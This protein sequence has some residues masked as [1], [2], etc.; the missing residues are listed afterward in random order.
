MADADDK[1][2]LIVDGEKLSGLISKMLA[3]D[4]STDVAHNGLNAVQKLREILPHAIVVEVDIPGNGIKLTELLG[5]NPKYSGVPIIL[6]A[7]NP[8]PD[9]II[10]SKNAGADSFLAKPFKPSDLKGRIAQLSAERSEAAASATAS[11]STEVGE[12]GQPVPD[13]SK[14]GDQEDENGLPVDLTNRVKS[15]EGLPSFPATHAEILKLA[16]SEDATSDD[17]AEKLQLD[18]GLLAT[19]F[20]LVNSS[21]YGFRKKVDSLKLAVTLLGLEEIANLVMAAQVF[22]KLGD[23]ED[24]SGLDANEFWRHSIGVAFA[25]RAISKKL[26]TEAESAFLAG[27]LHDVGKIVLDRYFVDYYKEVL[28]ICEDGKTLI[29]DAEKDVLGVTHA[30][31]GAVLASEWKF[32]NTYLNTIQYHH[33]PG[34]ARRYKRL[35]CLVHI[36]D[37]IT[38]ELGFGS[39]GDSAVPEIEEAAL[40]QF[41]MADRGVSML[42]EAVEE[43]LEGADSFL[44]ALKS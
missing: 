35:V 18:S 36:A 43:E 41:H 30:D 25:A 27:M 16:N 11:D 4:F 8:S 3:G 10:R 15:I 29:K 37:G 32:A 20:K 39:G 26:Q 19:I 9:M 24:G 42:K 1:N 40:D 33:L 34:Q 23:Y 17:I 31:I 12:D 21:G 6:T 2:V 13:G 14:V 38:R 5:V 44:A 28:T 7:A 22:E